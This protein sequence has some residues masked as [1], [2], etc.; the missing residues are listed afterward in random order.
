[1][2]SWPATLPE[3]PLE[4]GLSEGLPQQILESGLDGGR[5]TARRRHSNRGR[6]FTLTMVLTEAQRE[7]FEAFYDTTTKGG[8]TSFDWVHPIY[9]T[10]MSFRFRKPVPKF[11]LRG[12]A[13]LV[14]FSLE[15]VSER[16]APPSSVVTTSAVGAANGAGAAAAVGMDAAVVV[17]MRMEQNPPINEIDNAA[18]TVVGNA[19]PSGG[20]VPLDGSGDRL[21]IDSKDYL[22]VTTNFTLEAHYD[23]NAAMEGA[24]ISKGTSSGADHFSFFLNNNGH[25]VV[26]VGGTAI[27]TGV[28][29]VHGMTGFVHCAAV[30]DAAAGRWSV[31]VDGVLD[32]SALSTAKPTDT[33]STITIGARSGWEGTQTLNGSLDRVKVTRACL[34]P[35][36]NGNFTPPAR[37]AS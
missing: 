20:V 4:Q 27:I 10:T 5:P 2:V 34:Y 26:I 1:M 28:T 32:A 13:H 15:S 18:W 19:T 11:T 14:T 24:F 17:L 25:L 21:T 37:T 12:A 23:S 9:R 3:Y 16:V 29:N 8:V 22:N 35:Y 30:L 36:A 7:A 6:M 33:T 31:Y